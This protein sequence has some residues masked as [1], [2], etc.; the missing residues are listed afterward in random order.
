MQ[1]QLGNRLAFA[2][3]RGILLA[4]VAIAPLA[5]TACVG[6]SAKDLAALGPTVAPADV[7]FAEI[8][9]YAGR[10]KTAYSSE[11]DIR[12]AYPATIRVNSPGAT[13]AQYF[14]ERDDETRTQ[15]VAVRGTANKKNFAEDLEIRVRENSKIDIPVHSGFDATAQVLYADMKPHLKAGYKTHVTGHS[16]GGAIAALLA[17]YMVE[18][19]Y[20]VARDVTFG[21][22]K[23]TT[24]AAADRLDFLALTRVVDEN[25]MV[26]MLPPITTHDK[27]HGAY[28]HVGPEVILLEGPNYVFLADHDAE[29]LS[30]DEF[31]RSVSFASLSDHHMDKYL[32]RLST[33]AAGGVAVPYSKREKYVAPKQAAASHTARQ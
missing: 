31:W 28:E 2:I 20:T 18:D 23:F 25:D 27:T 9:A 4:I 13:D 15:Y 22:P 12:R 33:K 7:N 11:P 5:L 29:R 14:L 17:I 10:A 8:Y 32:R 6:G 19:G 3:R 1:F 30:V 21:Q 26:P 16:L 24:S